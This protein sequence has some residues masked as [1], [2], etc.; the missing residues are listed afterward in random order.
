MKTIVYPLLPTLSFLAFFFTFSAIAMTGEEGSLAKSEKHTVMKNDIKIV[1]TKN[2][3]EAELKKIEDQ[4]KAEGFYFAYDN[5]QYNDNH[6][7]IGISIKYR[8]AN[9]NSGNYS[10]S[11]QQPINDIVIVSE[12]QRL[13]VRSDGGANRAVI[14]Q[15]SGH[16]IQNSGNTEDHHQIMTERRAKMEKRMEERQKRMHERQNAMEN[17]MRRRMD[18]LRKNN[19]ERALQRFS[20]K[21]YTLGK[22]TT[23]EELEEIQANYD[24]NGITVLFE[25]AQ[26]NSQ[27]ELTALTITID[28]R[29]G[30]VSTSNFGNGKAAIKEILLGADANNSIM[31][32]KD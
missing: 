8:D 12:G 25:N 23:P 27:G 29:N 30:S 9:N 14:S 21:I 5:L 13:V 15:G 3:T 18:S 17:K 6:E 11:S 28:N 16:R 24:A 19:E 32:S 20:G 22:D 2:T 31:K 26:R 10:V 1:I 7:I 4:M